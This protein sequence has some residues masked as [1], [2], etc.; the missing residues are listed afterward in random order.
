MDQYEGSFSFRLLTL[1]LLPM[2]MRKSESTLLSKQNYRASGESC[3]SE[4]EYWHEGHCCSYCPAGTHV[5]KHCVISH[6]LGICQ[7]CPLGEYAPKNGLETCRQCAQCRED[8][9]ML[10][11][12][13]KNINAKCQC[14]EG[15]YCEGPD[16]KVCQPCTKRCP[17]GKQILQR[18]NATTDILCGVPGT[19]KVMEVIR[20]QV[21]GS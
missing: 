21:P 14:K 15:Y 20:K 3:D 10:M 1:L 11:P 5:Y 13:Y 9:E 2:V 8:Q 17:E 7:E 6:T 4:K 12:C 18:C 16:C 19:G